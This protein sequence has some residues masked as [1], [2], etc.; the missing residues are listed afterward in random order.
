[1]AAS[2]FMALV[3]IG[4]IFWLVLTHDT[5]KHSRSC[6][7]LIALLVRQTTDRLK[8]EGNQGESFTL[9]SQA[10]S[11]FFLMVY[12]LAACCFGWARG[13]L[14]DASSAPA[15]TRSQGVLKKRA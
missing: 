10:C 2:Q 9:V 13:F 5:V 14:I 1:V 11:T 3:A 4:V 8:T 6:E 15:H 7:T 12:E